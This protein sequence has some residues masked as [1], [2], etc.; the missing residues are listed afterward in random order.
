M[1]ITEKCTKSVEQEAKD[2]YLVCLRQEGQ[3]CCSRV[4]GGVE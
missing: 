3:C 1:E 4:S 2:G